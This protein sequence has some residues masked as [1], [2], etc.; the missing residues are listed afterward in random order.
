MGKSSGS[1]IK[2]NCFPVYSSTICVEGKK[3]KNL[4]IPFK[5]LETYF[6]EDEKGLGLVRKCISI[7]G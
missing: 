1:A 6:Q 3:L 5:A 7:Q 2:K 4:Q